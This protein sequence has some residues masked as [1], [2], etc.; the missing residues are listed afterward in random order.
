MTSRHIMQRQPIIPVLAFESVDQALE[1][2]EALIQ[3]G[4][5]VLE[6]TLRTDAGLDSIAAVQ[7]AFP[8]ACVGAGTVVNTDQLDQ[9]L[10][11]GAQF[12]V[13][14]GC[15]DRLWQA[16]R[17]NDVDLLAGTATVSEIMQGM[18]YGFDA[19]K[20][21]PAEINGGVAA[22]KALAGPLTDAVFCPTGGVKPSNVI[23]YLSLPNVLCCGGT[24]LTPS[25]ATPDQITQLAREAKDLVKDIR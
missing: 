15:T 22:L 4:L 25:Q 6:I 16:A 20:F 8:D 13:S 17:S 1:Q 5:D 14:P 11:A 2:S 19:F 21:F 10:K 7:N 9:V 23:D 18:E 24:W 3:G 12:V